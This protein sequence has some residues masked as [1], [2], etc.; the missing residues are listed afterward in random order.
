MTTLFLSP[1]S[2]SRHIFSFARK[3]H[4]FLFLFLSLS[5]YGWAEPP[6]TIPPELLAQFT[7]NGKIPVLPDY[8]DDSYPSDQPKFYSKK[9]IDA[10]IQKIL[11]REIG[12][13]GITDTWLYEALSTFPIQGKEVVII[14]SASP[15]YESIVIAFGGHPTTIE[16]NTL[17]T[18]D[19]RLT[20]MTPDEYQQNHKLF[21]VMLSI[22]SI[23][24]DGL[25]RYGDPINPNADLEFMHRAK[26]MLKPSG[27]MLLA[28]PIGRDALTWNLHRIYGRLRLPLLLKEWKIVQSFGFTPAEFQGMLGSYGYQPIF[29]LEPKMS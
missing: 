15:W 26:A 2:K 4:F 18:D 23:E 20:V 6:R 19:P 24:H 28:V 10:R 21:D 22:S 7:L 17:T 14:G 8:R 1:F 27:H 25:G 3:Q 12:H 16:Y 5:F 9:E 11:K 13:Y 29:Y